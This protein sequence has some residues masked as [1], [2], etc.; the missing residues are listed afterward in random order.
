MTT[1]SPLVDPPETRIRALPGPPGGHYLDFSG[2]YYGFHSEI[3]DSESVI[4][5][6]ENN[7]S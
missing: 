7:S 6:E 2:V 3:G 4:S 5:F 1:P